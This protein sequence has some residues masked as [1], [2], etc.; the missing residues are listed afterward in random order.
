MPVGW[1]MRRRIAAI[2]PCA[3]RR[4]LGEL[5]KIGLVREPIA[6]RARHRHYSSLMGWPA[7]VVWRGST[8][9]GRRFWPP[10]ETLRGPRSPRPQTRS[11]VRTARFPPVTHVLQPTC[12]AH[13]QQPPRNPIRPPLGPSIELKGVDGSRSAATSPSGARRRRCCSCRSPHVAPSQPPRI[14]P[15]RHR[16][17]TTTC[18][19]TAIW[20][21]IP[22]QP[23]PGDRDPQRR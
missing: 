15:P 22:R 10:S 4:R 7:S 20:S 9:I 3:Y 6:G 13:R 21:S 16:R 5:S 23:G 18:L 2:F 14:E 1:D 11:D 17:W 8:S 19:V 12:P